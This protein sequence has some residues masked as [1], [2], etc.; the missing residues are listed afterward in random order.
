MNRPAIARIRKNVPVHI[1]LIPLKSKDVTTCEVT[2]SQMIASC[3][4]QG[5]KTFTLLTVYILTVSVPLFLN[6]KN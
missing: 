4:L 3:V 6:R 1:R 2:L 5:S